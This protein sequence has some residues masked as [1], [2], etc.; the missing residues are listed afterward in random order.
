MFCVSSQLGA[1]PTVREALV[2]IRLRGVRV[3]VHDELVLASVLR[4]NAPAHGIRG[5]VVG[6][7]VRDRVRRHTLAALAA[8]SAVTYGVYKVMQRRT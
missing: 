8:Q 6:L 5:I 7:H 1:G 4:G 3:D 2:P